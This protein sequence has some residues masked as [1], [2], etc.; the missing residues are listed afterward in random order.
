MIIPYF[1][2]LTSVHQYLAKMAAHVSI[3]LGVTGVI[4]LLDG[5]V[6]IARVNNLIYAFLMPIGVLK[7]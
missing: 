5:L 3:L 1:Q 2:T 7:Q 4:A 6:Q